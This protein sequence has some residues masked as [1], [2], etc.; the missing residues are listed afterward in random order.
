[1][2]ATR[3]WVR[4]AARW[5]ARVDGVSQHLRLAM[6]ILTGISTATISLQQYGYGHLAGPLIGVLGVSMLVFAYLYAEGGVWNQVSRDKA[7]MSTNYAGPTIRIDDEMIARGLVAGQ[8]GQP[9]SD[10]ERQA[11]KDELDDAFDE[12]RDGIPLD[13]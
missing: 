11:I 10:H 6:L 3:W 12:Y 9:L 7:D 2:T 4:T 5:L 1:M 8:K 13:S